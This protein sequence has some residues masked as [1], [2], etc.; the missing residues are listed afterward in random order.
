MDINSLI[1]KELG[2]NQQINTFTK[3]MDTDTSDAYIDPQKYRYA[4]NLRLTTNTETNTGELHLVEGV[5]SIIPNGVIDYSGTVIGFESVRDY[6]VMVVVKKDNDSNEFS[7]WSVYVYNTKNN[8]LYTI[9]ESCGEHIW[10]DDWDGK[11]KPVSIIVKYEAFNIINLYIADGI[12]NLMVIPLVDE[13]GSPKKLSNNFNELFSYDQ[14]LLPPPNVSISAQNGYLKAAI[15]QYVY[16]R[17][18]KHGAASTLSIFSKPLSL[19]DNS[20]KGYEPDSLTKRAVDINISIDED[21]Y[22]NKLEIYRINF[23]KQGQLPIVSLIY[24][25]KV[26]DKYV[27]LGS[28]I[29]EISVEDL[30]SYIRLNI[31][32]NII[33]QKNNYLF[34]GNVEYEQSQ[35]DNIFKD[36]DTKI[37]SRGNYTE[38]Q[39]DIIQADNS[40]E[41][42]GDI[43]VADL[44]HKQFTGSTDQPTYDFSYWG[45]ITIDNQNRISLNQSGGFN[46]VG[47][48]FAWKYVFTDYHKPDE[49]DK[50]TSRRTYRRGEIYRFGIKLYTKD[51]RASSVKWMCDIMMPPFGMPGLDDFQLGEKNKTIN[52]NSE[53]FNS[54]NLQLNFAKNA[55]EDST[56]CDYKIHELGIE[57]TPLI[58]DDN[59]NFWDDI[60]GYE[61]VRCEK[62]V[63]DSYIVAQGIIGYPM[64]LQLVSGEFN[65]P[66]V[67]TITPAQSDTQHYENY[68]SEIPGKHF[69]RNINNYGTNFGT[70]LGPTGNRL[71]WPGFLTTDNLRWYNNTY[72]P[73]L[74]YGLNNQMNI[75]SWALNPLGVVGIPNKDYLM[76]ACPEY[77]YQMD[78]MKDITKHYQG[79]KVKSVVKYVPDTVN[80]ATVGVEQNP[81]YYIKS[82]DNFGFPKE[83]KWDAGNVHKYLEQVKTYNR[84]DGNYPQGF[85]LGC[86]ENDLGNRKYEVNYYVTSETLEMNWWGGSTWNPGKGRVI[87]LLYTNN[88]VSDD[89]P[90]NYN[91]Y[92]GD[93]RVLNNP[94]N[95]IIGS[96]GNTPIQVL[97]TEEQ[98]TRYFM[99]E[100]T[101]KFIQKIPGSSSSFN[102]MNESPGNSYKD[103]NEFTN[104]NSVAF[105]DSPKYEDFANT[106]NVDIFNWLNNSV[107]INNK[108]VFVNWSAITLFYG[109]YPTAGE[110]L[111]SLSDING[112][113][114]I[115][116]YVTYDESYPD[117]RMTMYPIGAGGRFMLFDIE[118]SAGNGIL[119]NITTDVYAYS[120]PTIHVANLLKSANPYGG[121]NSYAIEQS[122][123]SSFGNFVKVE[124]GQEVTAQP[125]KV[126]DG[127]A[128]MSLFSYNASHIWHSSVYVQFAKM[129]SVYIVPIESSIDLQAQW[130]S[131]SYG[132]N[133]FKNYYVQDTPSSFLEYQQNQD[134]YLYNTAYNSFYSIQKSISND[135]YEKETPIYDTRVH[136]SDQ[137]TIGENTDSWLVYRPINFIDVDS[138]HGVLTGLKTFK[139]KLI[140]WQDR[141]TGILSV[142]ERT[143]LK[144]STSASIILGNGGVLDRYD[145]FTTVYGMKPN[146]YANDVTNDALY[147]WDGYNKEILQY[148]QGYEVTPL[149]T[150]KTVKN[151][152]NVH[153]ESDTPSVIYDNKNKEILFNVVNNEAVVYSEQ[154]QAFTS[155]YTFNSVWYA[156]INEKQLLADISGDLYYYNKVLDDADKYEI[157]Y[158]LEETMR[159]RGDEESIDNL[160]DYEGLSS[161]IELHHQYSSEE[162]LRIVNE[163]WDIHGDEIFIFV[164]TNV[165]D[166]WVSTIHGVND[167][168]KLIERFNTVTNGLQ[169]GGI[170]YITMQNGTNYVDPNI[171]MKFVKHIQEKTQVITIGGAYYFKTAPVYPRLEYVVNP[172]SEYNKTFDTQTIGGRFYGGGEAEEKFKG[173]V[174]NRINTELSPLQF[175]YSTPL[176]Q[177][178]KTTGDKLTNVEYSYRLTIPRNG[179][180]TSMPEWGNRMR[181]NLLN[182]SISSD[183]NNLDFSI[184]YITTKFRISWS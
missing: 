126:F 76:F 56:S 156:R 148:T 104:I 102:Y 73:A 168:D 50:Q 77:C 36:F 113:N 174:W 26:V 54:E 1:R 65:L 23:Y 157:T 152:I 75:Y 143:M 58:R 69:I 162:I 131:Y 142:N 172:N 35:I 67:K 150:V 85:I 170:F 93:I 141:G 45:S 138:A 2:K 10:K 96:F 62:T 24:D 145:Y 86:H 81:A 71:F 88:I 4:E 38:E 173:M 74:S 114:N 136:Y 183:S 163:L 111:K 110:S 13:D 106:G 161:R 22:Q 171:R 12:H 20:S 32:P 9:I 92:E 37:Y 39:G 30:L 72:A 100:F 31:H 122:K 116:A 53:N 11:T 52:I 6:A 130:S 159:K 108:K 179:E 84:I 133:G 51:G 99:N 155:V 112:A 175:E 132:K 144:D 46:G 64:E 14:Y 27:D 128:F 55:E 160:Q 48:N 57:F 25:G 16:R 59:K 78:D 43:S 146:Q 8:K 29:K 147:W 17:Y 151:Y 115:N 118:K 66:Y 129:A 177:H 95:T 80:R 15:V 34:E 61:I 42:I 33:E 97:G 5:D 167:R 124:H 44:K 153:E 82:F 180:N 137:K 184:Q 60:Y 117:A 18:R 87:S 105:I 165:N 164:H 127:D 40:I 28:S 90:E 109:F 3:G 176:K 103:D 7:S 135:G 123:Y 83:Y 149:S 79:L 125:I 166:T 119:D 139:D 21:Q 19:Y 120:A 154:V 134:S 101:P 41:D 181:G 68:G 49:Y 182:G 94:T 70:P 91:M 63:E 140:F 158:S 107:S 47:K 98:Q 89:E 121:Y 178:S 169:D